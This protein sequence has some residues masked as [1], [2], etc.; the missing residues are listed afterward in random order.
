MG[1]CC[2]IVRSE[3]RAAAPQRCVNPLWV[4]KDLT[5]PGKSGISKSRMA[6]FMESGTRLTRFR[7]EGVPPPPP[8][9]EQ[10]GDVALRARTR[11]PRHDDYYYVESNRCIDSVGI[12]NIPSTA[13]T[14]THRLPVRPLG[15]S[16][17]RSIHPSIHR[18]SFPGRQ[19]MLCGG[20]RA[21]NELYSM[22]E[23]STVPSTHRAC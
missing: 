5:D 2:G 17:D 21:S 10:T 9:R 7:L 4:L 14:H 19:Q 6:S 20:P 3:R 8:A 11:V 22:P 15:R 18:P 12:V 13:S 16:I 23:P 1:Y